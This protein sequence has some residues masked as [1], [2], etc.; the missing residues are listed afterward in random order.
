MPN[1]IQRY[2]DHVERY[3]KKS[4]T[5]SIISISDFDSIIALQKNVR[6]FSGASKSIAL[7]QKTRQNWIEM[8]G[9]S[10]LT[11]I[12]HSLSSFSINPKEFNSY[13]ESSR[14]D[15]ARNMINQMTLETEKLK[16]SCLLLNHLQSQDIE[17]PISDIE[18]L[19]IAEG[20]ISEYFDIESAL[21]TGASAYSFSRELAEKIFAKALGTTAGSQHVEAARSIL[22]LQLRTE[23]VTTL[24]TEPEQINV[25]D[26]VRAEANLG[27]SFSFE[28]LASEVNAQAETSSALLLIV[29]WCQGNKDSEH[30]L[31]AIELGIRRIES[32]SNYTPSIRTL[33]QL[34]EGF[35]WQ[36]GEVSETLIDAIIDLSQSLDQY[37]LQEFY[38]LKINVTLCKLIKSSD[39]T[40]WLELY[41]DVDSIFDT[42]IKCLTLSH[43]IKDY[44]NFVPDLIDNTLN[45][46]EDAKTSLSKSFANMLND[47]AE[48][49]EITREIINN[50]LEFD[51]SLAILMAGQLNTYDRRDSAFVNIIEY[52]SAN[53]KSIKD[54]EVIKQVNAKILHQYTAEYAALQAIINS[55]EASTPNQGW[56]SQIF[57]LNKYALRPEK[58]IYGEIY[59]LIYNI[60]LGKTV[61]SEIDKCKVRLEQILEEIDPLWVK[62]DMA[63][64]AS[65]ALSEHSK[66]HA[67]HFLELA[68]DASKENI[69]SN[70]EMANFYNRFLYIIIRSFSGVTNSKS[71][72]QYIQRINRQI[73]II[74]SQ[75]HQDIFKAEF[76][77][78]LTKIGKTAEADSICEEL[79]QKIARGLVHKKYDLLIASSH[80]LAQNDLNDFLAILRDY[81]L[82]VR[83]ECLE[84]ALKY[85]ITG[86]SPI[87]FSQID[88]SRNPIHKDQILNI[89]HMIEALTF[90]ANLAYYSDKLVDGILKRSNAH[91]SGEALREDIPHRLAR[92][93]LNMLDKI[94]T[95]KLPDGYNIKHN[96]YIVAFKIMYMRIF[97]SLAPN[98]SQ[99]KNFGDL[100]SE[101]DDTIDNQAD[102]VFLYI[103]IGDHCRVQNPALSRR[104]LDSSIVE[105]EKIP[106]AM[107]RADRSH[108][109]AKVYTQTTT[110]EAAKG[111]I[112]F[113]LNYLKNTNY[114]S[115]SDSTIKNIMQLAHTIDPDY[116]STLSPLIGNPTDRHIETIRLKT[117]NA[118]NSP[119][120]LSK[121]T[122][123]SM[124][125]Q[126]FALRMFRER[127]IYRRGSWK[128]TDKK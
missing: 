84:K 34:S 31:K 59:K 36:S 51:A 64:W 75:I 40:L 124:R 49:W 103:S 61:E 35:K 71:I 123:L 100:I 105:I 23:S 46:T 85:N 107:D 110:Y 66:E 74:P 88:D 68:C 57:E 37:P 8:Y 82:C 62:V 24:G 116:A 126:K 94:I 47:L 41:F 72:D 83:E 60:K 76:S 22:A 38:R 43:M 111:M 120:E 118:R 10:L 21:S 112:N 92:S 125:E 122:S 89:M 9:F 17:I 13:L 6:I 32:D 14:F 97:N 55:V 45:F 11:S 102:K 79:K 119:R 91:M 80:A 98:G 113:S 53:I 115:R 5:Q 65:Q 2:A 54:I 70:N 101:V 81:P 3:Q 50:T 18:D 39:D 67:Q 4:L 95:Q 29:N 48:H 114:G 28:D 15:L 108:Y 109:L 77:L 90:D 56:V 42:D 106:S 1:G 7:N 20:G 78:T 104:I 117:L 86:I 30:L 58:R 52:L 99:L 93:V 26:F 44:V 128:I 12:T 69:F 96:G 33:R 27:K 73:N 121:V 87:E 19:I 63:F 127:I 16:Y 25:E